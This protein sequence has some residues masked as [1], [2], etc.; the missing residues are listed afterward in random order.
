MCGCLSCAPYGRPGLQPVHVPHLGIEQ[1]TLWF[2]GLCS[3][4]W[5]TPA[6]VTK[7]F[8][9]KRFYLFLERGRE[10]EIHSEQGLSPNRGMCPDQESNL[11]TFHFVGWCPTNWATLVR[12]IDK[13]IL[14]EHVTHLEG[15]I[16]QSRGPFSP[17]IL[18]FYG[19]YKVSLNSSGSWK[20]KYKD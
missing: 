14:I 19:V 4:H 5:A 11:A 16:F 13:M 20:Y 3:I 1:V 6:R 17:N 8:F 2:A 7:W 18:A 12:A 10:R 9:K 15:V